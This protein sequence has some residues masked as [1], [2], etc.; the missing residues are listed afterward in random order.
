MDAHAHSLGELFRFT[1]P[2]WEIAVRGTVMYVGLFLLLRW[3][4]RESAGLSL[5]DVLLITLLGDAA[6]NAMAGDSHSLADGA[7]LIGVIFAWDRGIDWLT[8][9][10][11]RVRR[12]LMPSPLELIRDGRILRANLR[13]EW[14]TVDELRSQLRLAGVEDPATVARCVLEPDGSVSVVKQER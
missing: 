14:I 12:W 9:R 4:R 13:R 3:A 6:Q 5:G 7:G 8:W 2:L 11:R 10:S 1:V